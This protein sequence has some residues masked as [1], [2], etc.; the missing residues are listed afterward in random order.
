MSVEYVG[1]I[2]CSSHVFPVAT[3]G[4]TALTVIVS[5]PLGSNITSIIN[6]LKLPV[7]GP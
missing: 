1:N 2:D 7:K 4:V 3:S 5:L 6:L